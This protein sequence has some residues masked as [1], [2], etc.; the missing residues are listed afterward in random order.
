MTEDQIR[1]IV[2]E[3]ADE[4]AEMQNRESLDDSHHY[5]VEALV[6]RVAREA[7]KDTT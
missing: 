2:R 6:R 5:F 4:L 1:Q 7:D 3:A